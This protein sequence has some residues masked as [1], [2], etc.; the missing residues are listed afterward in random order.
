MDILAL[1]AA[2]A[3]TEEKLEEGMKLS[4]EQISVIAEQAANLIGASHIEPWYEKEV[5]QW[6][7]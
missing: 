6:Q 3:Y 1:A 4:T 5:E 7:N 2:K